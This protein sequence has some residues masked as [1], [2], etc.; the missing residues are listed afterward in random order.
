MYCKV[1]FKEHLDA[2]ED[3][4]IELHLPVEANEETGRRQKTVFDELEVNN[5]PVQA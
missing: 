2:A 5:F 4:D 1:A 3:M